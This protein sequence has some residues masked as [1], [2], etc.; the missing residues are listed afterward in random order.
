MFHH[1]LPPIDQHEVG[2]RLRQARELAGISLRQLAKR[3][4][5][6]ASAVSQI[7][8]GAT[9]PSV[10][11]LYAL[12]VELALSLDDLL[13]NPFSERRGATGSTGSRRWSGSEDDS[14]LHDR[15]RAMLELEGGVRLERLTKRSDPLLDF[16]KVTYEPG[17]EFGAGGRLTRS[18]GLELGVILSGWL[19]LTVGTSTYRLGPGDSV[20]LKWA[21]PHLFANNGSEPV[22]CVW[23]ILPDGFDQASLR[24]LRSAS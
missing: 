8:T 22:S 18:E 1:P 12:A 20:S 24:R 3:V 6:S 21:E 15:D 2:R 19:D 10:K 4:G 17:S 16:L 7:E 5:L 11:T 23:V 13:D 9:Q 14:V